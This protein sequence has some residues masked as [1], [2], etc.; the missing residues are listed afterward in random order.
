LYSTRWLERAWLPQAQRLGLRYVAHVVQ[1]DTHGDIMT[2]NY[3]LH[4]VAEALELQLFHSVATAEEWLRSCQR[5][6]LRAKTA[7]RSFP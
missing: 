2:L 5:P 6:V 7:S 1:A 3:L 4:Y